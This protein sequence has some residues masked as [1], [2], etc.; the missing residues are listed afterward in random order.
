MAAVMSVSDPETLGLL[1]PSWWNTVPAAHRLAQMNGCGPATWKLK[2]NTIW[3]LDISP[4]CNVHDVEYAFGNSRS[5]AD[6]RLFA[7]ICLLIAQASLWLALPRLSRAFKMFLFVRKGGASFYHG[8][9]ERE[10]EEA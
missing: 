1:L 7:N 2:F 10:G 8:E 6:A 3:G 5:S 4:A 9:L